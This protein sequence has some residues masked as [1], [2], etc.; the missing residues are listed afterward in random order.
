MPEIGATSAASRTPTREVV[1][2]RLRRLELRARGVERAP[3][4][5]AAPIGEMKFWLARPTLAAC[6]RSASTSV[7]PAPTRPAPCAR[8]TRLCSSARSISPSAWPALTRL[9]SATAQRQQRARRL[10]AHDR[11]ARRDQRPGELDQRAASTHRPA[12]SPRPAMNSSGTTG[13]PRACRSAAPR[14]RRRPAPRSRRAPAPA[15]QHQRTSAE[16][17]PAPRRSTG[18]AGSVDFS[19]PRV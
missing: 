16:Q 15:R 9:P 19:W 8:C 13:L 4:R 7:A 10:G 12:A 14:R 1:E 3:A 17:P 6:W 2:L 18:G 5:S 11:G